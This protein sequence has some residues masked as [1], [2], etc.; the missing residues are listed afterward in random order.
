MPILVLIN[1]GSNFR[2]LKN[3]SFLKKALPAKVMN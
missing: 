1:S 3:E 2:G